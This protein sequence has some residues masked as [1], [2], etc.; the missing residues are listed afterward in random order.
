MATLVNTKFKEIIT[1][2]LSMVFGIPTIDGYDG[3]V[4]P[5]RRYLTYKRVAVPG[6]SRTSRTRSCA[7]SCASSRRP[8]SC[9]SSGRPTC[10]VDSIGDVTRDGVFYD[11]LAPVTVPSGETARFTRLADLGDPAR[12][13]APGRWPPLGLVSALEGATAV[14]DGAL[15]ATVTLGDGAGQ[16]WRADLVAGRD[17][18]EGAYAPGIRHRQPAAAD[19]G[20][21]RPVRLPRPPPRAGR[22]RAPPGWPCRATSRRRWAGCACTGCPSSA[23]KASSPGRSASPATGCG[24]CTARTSSSTGWRTPCPGPTSSPEARLVGRAGGRRADPRRRPTTAG[25]G[26]HPGARPRGRRR[27]AAGAPCPGRLRRLLVAASRSARRRHRPPPGHRPR[28][29]GP[30]RCA[31]GRPAAPRPARRLEP[32]PRQAAPPGPARHLERQTRRSGWP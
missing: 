25:A 23:G 14:P 12:P 22:R 13:T 31:R 7:T 1:P 15:V 17:T 30:A 26:G 27:R 18:A 21:P 10:C 9:A 6:R 32:P 29:P 28:R 2:N 24:S 5:L 3:G 16:R 11:L 20:A 4:L 8:P 19:P